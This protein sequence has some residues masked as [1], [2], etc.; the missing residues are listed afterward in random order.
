MV[1]VMTP[2]VNIKNVVGES[3]VNYHRLKP[4]ACNDTEV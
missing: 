4:V 1:M 2:D 3:I